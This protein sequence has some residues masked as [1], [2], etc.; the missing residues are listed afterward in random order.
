MCT[1]GRYTAQS[2]SSLAT[3]TCHQLPGAFLTA[4]H[5]PL[6]LHTKPPQQRGPE[7]AAPHLLPMSLSARPP[8]EVPTQK[9]GH[10]RHFPSLTAPPLGIAC[11]QPFRIQ[12]MLKRETSYVLKIPDHSSFLPISPLFLDMSPWPGAT[13]HHAS[14]DKSRGVC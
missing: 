9:E 4:F 14:P 10:I 3:L 1:Q 12:P 6:L 11:L 13:L 5:P 7:L 2:P 8:R